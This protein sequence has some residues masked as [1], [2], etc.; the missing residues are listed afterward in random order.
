M[1]NLSIFLYRVSIRLYAMAIYLASWR[2]NKA[3]QWVK[4]RANW[5]SRYK[6]TVPKSKSF[7]FHCASLGEY[8]AAKP[9]IEKLVEEYSDYEIIISFFSPSGY[10]NCKGLPERC[11]KFY[12]PL[13]TAKNA[14]KW[15]ENANFVA[16]FFIKYEYW[17]FYFSRLNQNQIPIFVVGAHFNAKQIFFK[18]WGFLHRKMLTLTTQIF[19]QDNESKLLLDALLSDKVLVT[20]DPRFDRA[21]AIT[22]IPF[23]L[24]EN[25]FFSSNHIVLIGGSTWPAEEFILAQWFHKYKAEYPIKLV[26][27][28]HDVSEAHIKKILELFPKGKRFSFGDYSA[29]DQVLIIDNIGMLSK[30]YRYGKVA[31]VG[32]GFGAGLH[33]IIEPAAY[34]MPVFYGPKAKKHPESDW[35]LHANAG[36][37]FSDVNSF[38]TQLNA[39]LS[40]EVVLEKTAANAKN[41]VEQGCGSTNKML[42]VISSHIK[43]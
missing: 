7:W 4:G 5:F 20:G 31:V 9:L 22:N 11:S 13:D 3:K 14:E 10:E 40:D 41:W 35:L 36:F 8:E 23:S 38:S 16:A 42:K 6:E 2:S 43:N 26:L 39:L 24:N 15:V 12:L 30:I 37:K 27:A 29:N 19:V 33:N 34:G 32:G 18:P 1:H 28:P 25:G 17:Y 21:L